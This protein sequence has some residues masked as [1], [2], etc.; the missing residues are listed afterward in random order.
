METGALGRSQFPSTSEHSTAS[1]PTN[2]QGPNTVRAAAGQSVPPTEADQKGPSL[3]DKQFE[4]TQP[5]I[6]RRNVIDPETDVLLF[7]AVEERTGEVKV[8]IPDDVLLNVRE[9]AR[10]TLSASSSDAGETSEEV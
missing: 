8:Q 6:D 5:T 9:Y 3:D 2:A 10:E 1:Q 4:Q 7:Q